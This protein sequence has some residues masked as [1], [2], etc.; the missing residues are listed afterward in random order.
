MEIKFLDERITELKR[1]SALAAG[2]D[3]KA[4]IPEPWIIRSGETIKIPTGVSINMGIDSS[5][6][7]K[8]VPVAIISPRSGLG[9]NGL[10]PR[11]APGIIDADY[12]GE[13]IV[14]LYNESDGPIEVKPLDRIAQMVI[15]VA[16]VEGFTVVTEFSNTTERGSGGFGSTGK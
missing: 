2:Y 5:N 1:G 10:K 14:C 13:I 16:L 12:Q 9:C 4:C 11:N 8:M 15:T 7:D 6:G 3:L